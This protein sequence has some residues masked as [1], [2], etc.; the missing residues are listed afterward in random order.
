MMSDEKEEGKKIHVPTKPGKYDLHYEGTGEFAPKDGESKETYDEEKGEYSSEDDFELEALSGLKVDD[1]I[2]EIGEDFFEGVSLDSDIESLAVE[3]DL[4]D[5]EAEMKKIP[6]LKNYRTARAKRISTEDHVLP[7][8]LAK[9]WSDTM[10]KIIDKTIPIS[11]IQSEDF[12]ALITSG[13][14]KNQFGV[15]H[16]EGY[17]AGTETDG[18]GRGRMTKACFGTEI[19]GTT[20]SERAEWEKY[21]TMCPEDNLNSIFDG[22]DGAREGYGY[23]SIIYNK[24]RV[25]PFTTFTMSDSLGYETQ[26]PILMSDDIDEYCV[27]RCCRSRINSEKLKTCKDINDIKKMTTPYGYYESQI[28]IPH[29]KL[30][31]Y[32][33]AITVPY[34][35]MK[36][37]YGDRVKRAI[38]LCK[39]KFPNI[40]IASRDKVGRIRE[41]FI[42]DSG[43]IEW[44]REDFKL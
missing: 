39:E 29:L 20:M 5:V 12:L 28:H 43:E 8:M 26:H 18:G 40:K 11:R 19:R 35:E 32:V 34:S 41:L 17:F 7:M 13:E 33:S 3:D 14:Y 23:I 9:E 30:E 37:Y 4:I 44:K 24:D 2:A 21:G 25:K 38:K 36:G 6:T 16:S 31:E 15:G 27:S 1:D 22:L 42:N 10:R